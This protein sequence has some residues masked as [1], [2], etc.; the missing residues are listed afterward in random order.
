M[1][2]HEKPNYFHFFLNKKTADFPLFELK[3]TYLGQNLTFQTI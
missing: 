3:T 1:C 2:Q